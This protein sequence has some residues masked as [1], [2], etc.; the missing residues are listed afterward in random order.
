[1]RLRTCHQ[2]RDTTNFSCSGAPR[3]TLSVSCQ[4]V[5]HDSLSPCVGR[6][7][8]R[9]SQ[10][11]NEDRIRLVAIRDN[12]SNFYRKS[13]IHFMY[14]NSVT[15]H[16]VDALTSPARSPS[17][18]LQA[19]WT[20]R[21][22]SRWNE[23]TG[24]PALRAAP[25]PSTRWCCSAG[26]RSQTRGPPSNTSSPS[27]KTTSQPRSHSTNQGTTCRRQGELLQ[28]MPKAGKRLWRGCKRRFYT[29]NQASS[30]ARTFLKE[31]F[32][33]CMD[34][35]LRGFAK[36]SL[37]SSGIP[38]HQNSP[39]ELASALWFKKKKETKGSSFLISN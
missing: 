9:W 23:A 11:R 37:L 28:K 4:R 16:F 35:K 13:F 21:S 34:R 8:Q 32:V 36:V 2:L 25:S 10:A 30:S 31:V 39:Q 1:M 27:W 14:F 7:L 38:V 5:Q 33:S 29:T 15:S 17:V 19:W 18:F 22:W 20:G 6:S 12:K 26:R 3:G 24:C